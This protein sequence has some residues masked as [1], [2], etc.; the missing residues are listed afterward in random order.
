MRWGCPLQ[1]GDALAGREQGKCENFGVLVGQPSGLCLGK[2][3]AQRS[4]DQTVCGLAVNRR[5]HERM[6]KRAW[7]PAQVAYFDIFRPRLALQTADLL[8]EV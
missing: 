7:R 5:R 4:L 8:Q 2:C 1:L 6:N 3:T